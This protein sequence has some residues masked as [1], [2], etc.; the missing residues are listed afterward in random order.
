METPLLA[1]ASPPEF[2]NEIETPLLETAAGPFSCAHAHTLRTTAKSKAIG[3]IANC[4]LQVEMVCRR[5][6]LMIVPVAF[7]H[8]KELQKIALKHFL[9]ND[10]LSAAQQYVFSLRTRH[11]LENYFRYLVGAIWI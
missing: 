5:F 7:L 9:L 1:F 6:T 3:P 2:W 10:F 4:P 8:T 11:G